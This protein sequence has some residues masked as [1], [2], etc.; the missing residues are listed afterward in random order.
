MVNFGQPRGDMVLVGFLEGMSLE[1][2]TQ[3]LSNYP[4]FQALAGEVGVDSGIITLAGLTEGLTC[5]DV[6]NLLPQLLKEPSV[7]FAYPRFG[8]DTT[9]P[10]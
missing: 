9:E 5:L 2:R 3:V 4:E 8:E 10:E 7:L 1:S 6:E